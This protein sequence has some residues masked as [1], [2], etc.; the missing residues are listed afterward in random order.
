MNEEQSDKLADPNIWDVFAL[1]AHTISDIFVSIAEFFDTSKDML[2]NKASRVEDDKNFHEY[3]ARTIE[4]L[5]KG[6]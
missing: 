4:T 2:L 3:A 5:R 1:F 6:E